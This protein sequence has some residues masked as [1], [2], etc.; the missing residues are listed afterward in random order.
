MWRGKSTIVPEMRTAPQSQAGRPSRMS[1]VKHVTPGWRP[2]TEAQR[3]NYYNIFG[4]ICL[5]AKS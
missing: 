4:Q 2:R 1:S 5:F 3:G